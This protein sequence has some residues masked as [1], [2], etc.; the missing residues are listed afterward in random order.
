M[1]ICGCGAMLHKMMIGVQL[2]L[3]FHLC[4]QELRNTCD[5]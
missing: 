4:N 5:V 3:Y 2:L 1:R